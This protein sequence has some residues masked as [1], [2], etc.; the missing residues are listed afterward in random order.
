[1]EW[2]PIE[3]APKDGKP[4]DIWVPDASFE[5]GGQRFSDMIYREGSCHESNDFD[6]ADGMLSLSDCDYT[7]S[8]VT[9]WLRVEPPQP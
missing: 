9:H 3:T 1:M 8:D 4:Y 2:Q 6:S 5:G 7:P